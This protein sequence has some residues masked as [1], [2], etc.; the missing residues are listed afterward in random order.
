MNEFYISDDVYS[1]DEVESWM[2]SMVWMTDVFWLRLGV[3]VVSV[4]I[5]V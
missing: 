5:V 1:L 3:F 4:G 2:G